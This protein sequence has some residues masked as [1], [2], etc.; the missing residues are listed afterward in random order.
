MS[1]VL[2]KVA[3]GKF[4][5]RQQQSI[6]QAVTR[7]VA[8]GDPTQETSWVL[9]EEIDPMLAGEPDCPAVPVTILATATT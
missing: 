2:I 8:E 3:G 6:A 5:L 4:T 1:F 9:V 7:V